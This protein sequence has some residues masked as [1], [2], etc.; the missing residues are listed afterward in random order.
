MTFEHAGAVGTAAITA[1]QALRDKGGLVPGQRVLINGASGGVGT[2]AVQIAKALGAEV[3]AVCSTP[4]VEIARSLGA[5]VVVDYRVEDVT[6]RSERYDLVLDIAGTR[7]FSE[8]RQDAPAQMRPSWSS[9]GRGR[10][11]SSGPIGHVAGSRLRALRGSQRATFFLAQFNKADIETL[12]DLMADGKLMTAIDSTYPL[13][14]S[15][16]HF[17]TWRRGT[18]A[19]RSSSPCRARSPDELVLDDARVEATRGEQDVGVEPEIGDLLDEPL[20]ALGGAGERDLDAFLA[21]LARGCGRARRRRAP[22]TYEPVGS[23]LRTLGDAAPEP[24]REA[25]DRTGVA[26]GPGGSHAQEDRVAVAVVAKLLDRERVARR[27]ALAPELAGA[28]G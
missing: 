23:L 6:Q 26:R 28:S 24:R 9:E 18:H 17:N 4:N 13:D 25:R 2:Y 7:S 5:D 21:D 10:T 22:A 27:L 8:L 3:T 1:L 15:P 14:G 12:R 11:D 19:A 16:T 20:V